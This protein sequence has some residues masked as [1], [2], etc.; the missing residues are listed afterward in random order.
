MNGTV[1]VKEVVVEGLGDSFLKDVLKRGLKSVS[2]QLFVD[3]LLDRNLFRSMR[4][5]LRINSELLISHL[6]WEG[7]PREA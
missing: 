1:K 6:G 4:C 3:Q 7:K 2:D 5:S